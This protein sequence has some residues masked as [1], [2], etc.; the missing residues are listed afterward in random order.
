VRNAI[1]PIYFAPLSYTSIFR[2][3]FQSMV[4]N[5]FAGRVFNC[6]SDCSVK[7]GTFINY[8]N[9]VIDLKSIEKE[10]CNATSCAFATGEAVI[11]EINSDSVPL[12]GNILI[13][14]GMILFYRIVTYFVLRFMKWGKK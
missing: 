5:E 6:S 11:K 7:N 4:Q 12:Y 10:V 9:I 3:S 8:E 1:V 13:M 2:Y 14:V